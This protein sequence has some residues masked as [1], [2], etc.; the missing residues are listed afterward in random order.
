MRYRIRMTVTLALASL[1]ALIAGATAT[2]AQ[3]SSSM[4]ELRGQVIDADGAAIANAKLTLTDI[5]KGSSRVAAS[6]GEGAYVFL[7]LPPSSYE[8]QVEA[9]GFSASATRIELT[10]GRQA[11]IPIKLAAGKIEF[12]VDVVGGGEV[13]EVNR[14]EQT[15]TVD[16]KQITSLPINRRNFLD[17]A[18]LT[19]GV[20]SSENI[21]D[22]TD[23]R[24]AQ[25]PQSGLSFGGANGRGNQV[26]V[27]GA[28][29]IGATG[30]VL[31]LVSQEA[32]QEFQ[33][34]RN[35]FSA[36]FG[37]ASGGVVNIVSRSGGASFHG[38]A[39]G[40]FRHEKFDA[41]NA[42]DFNPNGKSPFNRQQYGGSVGGPIV[43][44]KT[45]FFTSV[46]RLDQEKTTFINLLTDPSLFQ[47]TTVSQNATVRNQA[48]LFE[49]IAGSAAP[50][51]LKQGAAQLRAALG[52]TTYPRTVKLFTDATGQ[53]PFDE[54]QT[55]FSAR[56][57]H[58]FSDRWTGYL[59]FNLTDGVFENQAAGSLIAVSRGRKFDTFNGGLLASH[60]FQFSNT[61]LN[62]LKL[63]VSYTRGDYLPNDMIGPEL[64]IE[65]FGAFGRQIF[66]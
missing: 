31:A 30:G 46:E 60:N 51:A 47:V 50:D 41:R 19:P 22:A 7:G 5:V 43:R 35:G 25:T 40:L 42:F 33:V 28:E 57:D 3:A 36:E 1:A 18:L 38:S 8:L 53:F 63:Q 27:D 45:F 16:A 59:R 13:V 52:T 17:Y 11:N 34:V 12:Q 55:Q 56:L 39:F 6:D 65:G 64:N 9:R 10:V 4:A 23:F 49:F 26:S 20:T 37:G 61:A 24:I 14:T 29:T 32:V 2:F 62:E 66:L 21:T 15:S 44:D 48:A 54:G 58:N